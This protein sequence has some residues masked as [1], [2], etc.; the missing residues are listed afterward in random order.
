MSRVRLKNQ[1]ARADTQVVHAD[2]FAHEGGFNPRP[3]WQVIDAARRQ[4]LTGEL[5]LATAPTTSVYLRD[6]EVYFAERATDSALGVRLMVAGVITRSQLDRGVVL[7]GSVEHLGRMFERDAS[8]DRTSVETAVEMM[9]D[10]ALVAAA[11]EMIAGYRM[12][13]YR[14]HSSGI[15]RWRGTDD[16]SDDSDDTAG[17]VGNTAVAAFSPPP[18]AGAE[19]TPAVAPALPAPIV[20]SPV[21]PPITDRPVL[22]QLTAVDMVRSIATNDLAVEVAAAVRHAL[23]AIDAAAQPEIPLMPADFIGG[24]RPAPAPTI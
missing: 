18:L 14:R 13:L 11:N 5:A 12:T 24:T 4:R 19:H 9:T 1:A 21:P 22:H 7:V 23:A 17:A 3:A 2:L 16:A 6:G 10:D 8:I 15:D 20:H